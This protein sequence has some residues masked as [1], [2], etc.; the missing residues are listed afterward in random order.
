MQNAE[1]VFPQSGGN[2][3]LAARNFADFGHSQ[4]DLIGDS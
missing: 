2:V 3:V 1:V 4:K